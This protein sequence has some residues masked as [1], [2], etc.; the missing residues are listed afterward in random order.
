M[1]DLSLLVAQ[2]EQGKAECSLYKDDVDGYEY[3]NVKY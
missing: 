2:D 3:T 1:G